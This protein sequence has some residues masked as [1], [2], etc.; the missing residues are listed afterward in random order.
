MNGNGRRYNHNEIVCRVDR[1]IKRRFM[2]IAYLKGMSPAELGGEAIKE[3]VYSQTPRKDWW[4]LFENRIEKHTKLVYSI[5]TMICFMMIGTIFVVAMYYNKDSVLIWA[6]MFLLIVI[7][8]AFAKL[9]YT[10]GSRA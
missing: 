6:W 3:W 1:T 5:Y 4:T 9:F 10:I 2:D 8:L 7:M